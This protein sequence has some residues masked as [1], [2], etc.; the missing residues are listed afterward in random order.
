VSAGRRA[1]KA[2]IRWPQFRKMFILCVE[3]LEM[4]VSDKVLE[5]MGRVIKERK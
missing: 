3:L 5:R 2:P 1:G 4:S